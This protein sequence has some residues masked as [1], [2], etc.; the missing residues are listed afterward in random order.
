M[1]EPPSL[2]YA[3]DGGSTS[4][5]AAYQTYPTYADT[6]EAEEE[7]EEV[8]GSAEGDGDSARETQYWAAN[9]HK[10]GRDETEKEEEHSELFDTRSSERADGSGLET[11]V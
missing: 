8:E 2:P 6:F 7:E 3:R 4:Q 1:A 5:A 9:R 11:A 10:A